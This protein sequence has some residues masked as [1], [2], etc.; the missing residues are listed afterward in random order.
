ML[1]LRHIL[2]FTI[3]SVFGILQYSIIKNATYN[4]GLRQSLTLITN[5]YIDRSIENSTVNFVLWNSVTLNCYG[6]GE[7]NAQCVV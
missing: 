3:T 2:S 4:I 7:E 6:V 5:H 1:Y